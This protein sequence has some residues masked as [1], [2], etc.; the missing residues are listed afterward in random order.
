LAE[1]LWQFELRERLKEKLRNQAHDNIKVRILGQLA[2]GKTTFLKTIENQLALGKINLGVIK[3]E[4]EDAARLYPER[5][6]ATND[7]IYGRARTRGKEVTFGSERIDL[8][9]Y[10]SETNDLLTISL[11]S[12]GGHMKADR[13]FYTDHEATAFFI[14]YG[15]MRE[16]ANIDEFTTLDTKLSNGETILEIAGSLYM[17][18]QEWN[19]LSGH[20]LGVVS[21]VPDDVS[22]TSDQL[23]DMIGVYRKVI[24]FTNAHSEAINQ[25]LAWAGLELDP[26]QPD[27]EDLRTGTEKWLPIM[28]DDARTGS[29]EVMKELVSM[30]TKKDTKLVTFGEEKGNPVLFHYTDLPEKE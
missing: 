6:P 16:L 29:L 23:E 12:S 18:L 9:G 24:D 20:K 28:K 15:L 3:A 19:S 4:P 14:D 30:A 10:T 25:K 8:F 22:L 26:T 27:L 2:A 7:Y 11:E 17:R 13:P 1:E 5:Q 21:K